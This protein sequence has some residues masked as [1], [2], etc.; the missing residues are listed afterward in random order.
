MDMAWHWRLGNQYPPPSDLVELSTKS[1]LG[2]SMPPS[3]WSSQKAGLALPLLVEGRPLVGKG[4]VEV[5]AEDFL[6]LESLLEPLGSASLA[7]SAKASKEVKIS[8]FKKLRL[9]GWSLTF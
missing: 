7:H 4:G 5:A 9:C 8:S 3:G 1:H 2:H 6:L